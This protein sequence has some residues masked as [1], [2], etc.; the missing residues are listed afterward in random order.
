MSTRS[1][2]GN[3]T[4]DDSTFPTY[5]MN[6]WM[7]LPRRQLAM[8]LAM[9]ADAVRFGVQQSAH[10]WGELANATLKWQADLLSRASEDIIEQTAEPTLESLQRVF[11]ASL[12]GRNAGAATH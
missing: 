10:F 9:H 11:E 4:R 2:R 8:L 12:T 3:S 6:A 1:T 7:E 5:A